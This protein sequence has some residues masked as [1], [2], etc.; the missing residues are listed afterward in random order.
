[1]TSRLRAAEG[2]QGKVTRA[3]FIVSA[4]FIG[5]IKKHHWRVRVFV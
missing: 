4:V 1:V 5:T 2:E 3:A